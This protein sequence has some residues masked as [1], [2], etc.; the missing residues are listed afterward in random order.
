M[1]PFMVEIVFCMVTRRGRKK[2]PGMNKAGRANM[3][4]DGCG[5]SFVPKDD[6]VRITID[7]SD[8]G[9]VFGAL[10]EMMAKLDKEN[11]DRKKA[12]ESEGAKKA[13]KNLLKSGIPGIESM[14]GGEENQIQHFQRK[15]ERKDFTK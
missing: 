14:F 6:M 8:T 15:Q 13:L 4:N 11:K 7:L 1:G 12:G 2:R 5:Q 3:R 9:P 10:D